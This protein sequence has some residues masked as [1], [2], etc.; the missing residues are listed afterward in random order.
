MDNNVIRVDFKKHLN[1]RSTLNDIEKL[2]LELNETTSKKEV[3]NI[4]AKIAKLRKELAI[5][6]LD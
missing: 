5:D 4:I 2:L 6:S 1:I 3:N